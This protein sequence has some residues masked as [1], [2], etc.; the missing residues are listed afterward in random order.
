MIDRNFYAIAGVLLGLAF[1][2]S[3]DAAQPASQGIFT[4]QQVDA[5]K[6]LYEAKCANCHAANLMGG[7]VTTPI[8]GNAF[9]E[10]WGA[11]PTAAGSP[12][13]TGLKAADLLDLMVRTMPPPSNSPVAPAD[14]VTILAYL[15]QQ[16]GFPSSGSALTAQTA[17]L[18]D[19]TLTFQPKV[20]A[21]ER[22][23]RILVWVDRQGRETAIP[24]PPGDYFLFRL[25][26]DGKQ[27][28]LEIQADKPDIWIMDAATGAL[29]RLTTEG[30]N[31]FPMW[32]PD[33]K[34]VLFASDRHRKPVDGKPVRHGDGHDVYWQLAD[35][36]GQAERLTFGE[37]PHSPQ[38]WAPDGKTLSFYEIHPQNKRDIWTMSIDGDRKPR[39]FLATPNAEAG[40]GFSGDGKWLAYTTDETGRYEIFIR[41]FPDA[42]H[43]QQLTTEGGL[44]LL[45]P[46]GSKEFFYRVGKKRFARDITVGADRVTVGTPKEMFEGD[47]ITSPGTRAGWDTVDGQH[48]LFLK[49]APGSKPSA[50]AR[51]DDN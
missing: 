50:R 14:Q 34:R 3:A 31:R 27:I 7:A 5:G 19:T 17:S 45:W 21:V 41:A 33:G 46:L 4:A 9:L 32:S 39:P 40:V 23:Q 20:G 2:Q 13:W 35:G 51:G 29:R 48:F 26:P 44:E 10:K 15:L 16:N 36:T 43:K 37:Y 30:A 49:T 11:K 1:A 47:Y 6:A 38:R 22:E 25:S 8:I 12:T 18:R 24:A 28:A 42:S